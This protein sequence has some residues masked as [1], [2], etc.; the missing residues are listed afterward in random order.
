MSNTNIE[1][2]EIYPHIIHADPPWD[3]EPPYPTHTHGLTEIGM[4]EFIIDPLAFGDQGN[5][6]RINSAYRFFKKQK[7][8]VKLKAILNGKT[9]KLT[10]EQLDLKYMKMDPYVYCFREVTV[11][12]EAVKLAYGSG[13]TEAMPGI[14]FIQIY[15]EGDDYVLMD[16]YYRGGVRW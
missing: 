6:K 9:I 13:V 7:N 12:F 1:E 14:R 10:G 11:E 3:D 16:D 15:V 8:A 4:P 5:G 2:P